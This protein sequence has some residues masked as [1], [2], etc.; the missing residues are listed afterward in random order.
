MSFTDSDNCI[1]WRSQ[2]DDEE[3]MALQ[4]LVSDLKQDLTDLRLE[5]L[6]YRTLDK[7]DF[8]PG[9]DTAGL[10]DEIEYLTGENK[11]LHLK[12]KE[13]CLQNAELKMQL[14]MRLELQ[15]EENFDNR[16]GLIET[17][18]NIS[19]LGDPEEGKD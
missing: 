5:Y 7:L 11:D 9:E 3:T 6:Q 8:N 17:A 13:I 12:V 2:A 18:R 1:M 10:I 16:E 15:I 4:Q 19:V 14:A